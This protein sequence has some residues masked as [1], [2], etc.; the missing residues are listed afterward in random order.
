MDGIPPTAAAD[1]SFQTI[2]LKKDTVKIEG[3]AQTTMM[4]GKRKQICD[5][6]IDAE[7]VATNK[8]GTMLEGQLTVNDVTADKGYEFCCSYPKVSSQQ[9]DALGKQM[10][11]L[12][13]T[14][15]NALGTFFEEF[16]A[17]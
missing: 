1:D 4:R 14:I 11:L 10:K 7:W 3:D 15:T 6:T 5:F 13:N 12:Q 2:A 9:K 16:S 8:D 17:K